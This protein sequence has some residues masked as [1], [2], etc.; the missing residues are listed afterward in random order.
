MHQKLW[1]EVVFEVVFHPY[2]KFFFL[3]LS[4]SLTLCV[5]NGAQLLL[6]WPIAFHDL[7]HLDSYTYSSLLKLAELEDVSVCVL[8]FSVTVVRW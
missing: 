8:D 2:T 4:L 7:E 6:G 3:S 1:A 5:C